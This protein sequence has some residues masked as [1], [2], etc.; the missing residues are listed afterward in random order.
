MATQQAEEEAL[1]KLQEEAVKKQ[2]RDKLLMYVGIGV[3]GAA[4]VV[5]IILAAY[6]GS[7]GSGKSSSPAAP[8]P[9]STGLTPANEPVSEGPAAPAPAAEQ[10]KLVWGVNDVGQ[11]YYCEN[12]N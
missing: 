4:L 5:G 2:Q 9:S 10:E 11:I 12:S 7:K 6:Y 8:S 3:G 1:K